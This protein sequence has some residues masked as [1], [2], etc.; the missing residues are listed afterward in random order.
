MK[1][2]GVFVLIALVL[3][4]APA[5]A[6]TYD[7]MARYPDQY[8]GEQVTITGEVSQVFYDDTG[9]AIRM[10][11]GKSSYG[12]YIE[13]DLMVLFSP[14]PTGMRVLEDDIVT[15]T[16]TFAGE[17]KYETLLGATRTVPGII[18]KTVVIQ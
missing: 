5:S 14:A 10:Y 2:I 7:Q 12:N 1:W 18:G 9:M 15:V 16:G 17:Y 3:I 13:D 11:T 8:A 6:L 4:S